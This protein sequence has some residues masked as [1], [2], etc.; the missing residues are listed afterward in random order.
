MKRDYKKLQSEAIKLRKAG[1]SY[2][3]IRKKLNV[4]KSTLSLWLKS[5]PLTPEQ[6]ARLYTKKN[7]DFSQRTSKPKRKKEKR[8]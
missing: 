1:L 8:N 4:A 6:K 7:F 2:G 5:I 3:E